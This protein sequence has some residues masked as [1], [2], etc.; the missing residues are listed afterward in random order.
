MP[1]IATTWDHVP[2]RWHEES[3]ENRPQRL[4]VSAAAL[5]DP[6]NIIGLTLMQ[7]GYVF[8]RRNPNRFTEFWVL[9]DAAP[10]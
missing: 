5:A 6:D 7:E 8:D 4:E 9:A 2:Q 10:A 1:K 3:G